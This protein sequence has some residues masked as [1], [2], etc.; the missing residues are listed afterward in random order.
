[1][2]G[3]MM[4]SPLLTSSLIVHAARHHSDT[5]IVSRSVE[6]PIHRTTYAEAEARAGRLAKALLEL[7]IGES[8]RVATLAWNGYRH[9][10]LY[11]GISGLGA[12]CHTINP[13]LFAD[14]LAYI[15]NHA[16]DRY[17]FLDPSFVG[18]LEGLHE[19]LPGVEGFVIM[20]DAEHM[21]E[22]SLPS[23]LCYETLIAAQDEGFDW[24][25]LDENL[26]SGLCYTSGTTGNPKGALY[27]HRSTVLHSFSCCTADHPLAISCREV[28]LPVVPMFHVQAWGIPY[29]AAMAGAKLVLPGPRLDGESLHELLQAERVTITAGVPT[30]W[31]G[32]LD[33]LA[34][35]GKTLDHLDAL[36]VGG[37]AAPLS[38]IEAFEEDHG[39]E[40]IH[41]WGMTETS[42]VAT[43]G[44]LK[45]KFLN[46]PRAE[47]RKIKVTQGRAL[48]GVETKIADDAGQAQPH[49]GQASGQLMVRGPWVASAY[50]EDPAASAAAFDA[51]G[52]FATGDVA[53]IDAD[54]HIT[55]TDRSK[56][57]IKSGG[58]W[59][60]SIDLENAA[61]G[62]PEVAEAAAIALPH[63]KWGERPLLVIVR[64]E[65]GAGAGEV[66][67]E[68]LRDFLATRVAKWWLP[69][70]IAFVEE[71]P[72]TATGKVSKLELRKIYAGHKLPDA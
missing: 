71:L 54:G 53:T 4:D 24:P 2:H 42:P 18:L 50:F 11:F 29:A 1:M 25:R 7:G 8:D 69:D 68:D 67:A 35:T 16:N 65:A 3:L 55:I 58:E 48:Y 36:L 32:L 45:R 19:R 57:L 47:Q 51:A 59:I 37:S 13:R 46:L 10:E 49:D 62:H 30:I 41:A 15:V 52:W 28:V 12:V 64:R 39:V 43:T 31:L 70:E 21:P 61:M 6:G 63:P 40:V 17:I 33:Y 23:V 14:Q 72:H 20:T 27:S 26:A 5:E 9:M 60:S 34:K 66:T 56:D 38:M 22:T 44:R